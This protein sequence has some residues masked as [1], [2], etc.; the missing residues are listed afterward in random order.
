MIEQNFEDPTGVSDV[1]SHGNGVPA[2]LAR[3]RKATA[4][5]QMRLA[6]ATWAEISLALG[7]ATP[8]SAL[9]AV[10]KALAKELKGSDRTKLREMAS[11]RLDRL[12]R[13]VWT[14]AVDQDNPEHLLAVTKAREI[15]STFTKL[16]GL[17]A[18][19]EVIVH[20][21]TTD[22]IEQ[23]VA[24]AVALGLPEVEEDDILDVDFEDLDP[25]DPDNPDS[26]EVA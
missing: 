2:Q 17:D 13:S 16:H 20:S 19:S 23:W 26:D 9:V 5:I 10:E 22:A 18:P 1:R 6:G 8:R 7:Y 14:K 15:I 4:G 25:D 11:L 21:P 12:L 3:Q 24:S